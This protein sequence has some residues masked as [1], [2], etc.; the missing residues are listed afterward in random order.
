MS[1]LEGQ[2]RCVAEKPILAAVT[3]PTPTS[4]L[5]ASPGVSGEES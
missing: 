4:R 5:M 2:P 1:G 3:I